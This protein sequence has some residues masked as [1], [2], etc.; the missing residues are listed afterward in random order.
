[1]LASFS[2]SAGRTLAPT[3]VMHA[4][5]TLR[6]HTTEGGWV[7]EGTS[8]DT[9]LAVRL[10]ESK[11]SAGGE[12][13][14]GYVISEVDEAKRSVE[15]RR[16]GLLTASTVDDFC[17]DLIR[18]ISNLGVVRELDALL[19]HHDPEHM[20]P[21]CATL[22]NGSKAYVRH[23][24][25]YERGSFVVNGCS[26]RSGVAPV[27]IVVTRGTAPL[28][29]DVYVGVRTSTDAW[30]ISP[31]STPDPTHNTMASLLEYVNVPGHGSLDVPYL[32]RTH[33][34]VFQASRKLPNVS[35]FDPGQRTPLTQAQ[36]TCIQKVWMID[37]FDSVLSDAAHM[38]RLFRTALPNPITALIDYVTGSTD[39]QD[40]ERPPVIGNMEMSSTTVYELVMRLAFLERALFTLN[41]QTRG[42]V[43]LVL[44][45]GR[46][47][48]PKRGR[49]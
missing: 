20:P 48:G 11:G 2:V 12:G 7:I 8:H 29:D 16:G 14:W 31:W 17:T 21:P 40:Q 27:D 35:A 47:G 38:S 44:A 37:R 43:K 32:P 46:G 24:N 26:F 15:L 13:T 18:V 28:P 3:W 49:A 1:M 39:H 19:L 5:E 23:Q 9:S 6:A 36:R 22:G 10:E 41:E 30:I 33:V 42:G 4:L 25:F 34:C 45:P